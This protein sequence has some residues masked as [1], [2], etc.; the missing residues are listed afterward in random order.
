[1]SRKTNFYENSVMAE[2]EKDLEQYRRI[3]RKWLLINSIS[4]VVAL[5]STL[6]PGN[7]SI[8]YFY[9]PGLAIIPEWKELFI[10]NG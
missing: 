2:E 6:F 3:T 7:I 4:L 5:V 9:L 8:V 1:M 10:A